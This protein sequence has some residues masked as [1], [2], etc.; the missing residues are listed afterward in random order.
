MA[1]WIFKCDPKKYLLDDRLA[2][3]D[4]VLTWVVSRYRDEIGPG[5]MAFIWQTG[6]NRGI[7]AVMRVDNSPRAMPD[8]ESE[9]KYAVHLDNTERMRVVGSLIERQVNLPHSEIRG[10]PG[11]ENL[12]VFHG[13]QQGTNFPVRQTEGELLL[14]LIAAKRAE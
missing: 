11:L 9:N 14:K 6:R 2:D 13:F 10:T 8:L 4:E 12:S 1:F 7:R 5:D 3:S